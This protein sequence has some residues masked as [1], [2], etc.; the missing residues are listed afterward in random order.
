MND[1]RASVRSALLSENRIDMFELSN[2][3]F[4]DDHALIVEG[5]VASV[6]AKK[7]ALE[8]IGALPD[9]DLIID[10]LRVRP[11]EAMSDSGIRAHLRGAYLQEPSFA[12]LA[13]TQEA[14]RAVSAPPEPGGTLDY[15]VADGIVTLNGS[16]PGLA[17]KRLA[18]LLAWWVPGS[19][20]V[21][22]GLSVAGDEEDSP[23]AVEEAVRIALEK[24]PF[25]DAG[26]IRVGARHH[27]VRLTGIVATDVQKDMAENDA[28]ATFGV[29]DV[30]NEI[31]VGP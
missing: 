10:R 21:I 8:R 18:G 7:L 6:K 14:D 24:D 5:I 30:I 29:D 13:I 26:Q 31:A 9:V 12:G 17:S 22:N 28:W 19:R 20:D 4:T 11:A 1:I 3:S 2:V 15:S 16:V 25:I 23:Q 27:V